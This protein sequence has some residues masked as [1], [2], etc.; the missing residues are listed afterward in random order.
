MKSIGAQNK[1]ILFIFV[2][3]SGILG[4]IGGTM[5]ILFGYSIAKLGGFIAAINGLSLLK[6]AFP[7]WLTIGSLL[8]AF[9]VGAGS[10]LLPAIQ[11]SKLNPVDALRYE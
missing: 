8:F 11:A 2:A 1:F 5:G 7:L 9:L 10:G 3:E 4:L 6:P